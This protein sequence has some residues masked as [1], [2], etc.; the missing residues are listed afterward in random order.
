MLRLVLAAVIVFCALFQPADARGER[1]DYAAPAF[2]EAIESGFHDFYARDFERAERSFARALVAVPDNTLA[3]A[4]MNAAAAH[5]PGALERLISEEQNLAGKSPKDYVARVRLGFSYLFASQAVRERTADARDELEAAVAID[6]H[7]QAA[8]VGIGI[9]R[10]NE[11]S[12]N[13]AK[14][15]FLAALRVDPN[16]VLA[17]EYLATI[18][19]VD[20]HEPETSL[21]YDVDVPNLVPGYADIQFH[22]ASI[23]DDLK[24]YDAALAYATRGI[25]LDVGRAGE[26][27]QYGYTLAARILLK[28]KKVSEAKKYLGQAVA[29]D[30]DGIYA[31]K[32]LDQIAKGDYDDKQQQR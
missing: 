13:R 15:E 29:F 20:L 4:F 28:Q 27:G 25:A 32:L 1:N 19:Q 9:M 18:Y 2:S 8:R 16:N 5:V 31:Q 23:M 24:Q 10:E 12:A 22:L 26:A 7:G 14:V 3:I 11:R 30:A 21:K 17:R 6:P